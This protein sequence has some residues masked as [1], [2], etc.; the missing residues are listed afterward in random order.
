MSI[1]YKKVVKVDE[2]AHLIPTKQGATFNQLWQVFYYTR[3]LKYATYRHYVLIKRSF[4]KICTFKNLQALCEL[5]YLKSPRHEVYCATD[6]VLPILN[7]AGY[8]T[9]ILPAVPVGQGYINEIKNSDVFVQAIKLEHFCALLY[10]Q[11]KESPD[12]SPYLKPDALLVLH[13]ADEKKYKLIFLEVETEKSNWDNYLETKK[14][15]YLKLSSDIGF[16]YYW[17]KMCG[18]LGFPKPDISKIKFSVKFIG[19]INKNFGDG[20]FCLQNLL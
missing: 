19:S 11:F 1:E 16:Y 14:E 15:N 18:L 6:K 5:G 12:K 3:M 17:N 2:V 13:D 20:F 8:N 7:E 10:P 9:K 4:N